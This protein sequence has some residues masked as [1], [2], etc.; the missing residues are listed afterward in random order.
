MSEKYLTHWD[1]LPLVSRLKKQDA[2]LHDIDVYGD[3]ET[4]KLRIICSGTQ[5]TILATELGNNSPP[6]TLTLRK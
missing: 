5:H 3:F 4:G 1:A 6:Y 2:R